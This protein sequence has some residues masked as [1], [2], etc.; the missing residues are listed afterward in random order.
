MEYLF[1]PGTDL[2][3]FRSPNKNDNSQNK[4]ASGNEPN[5]TCFFFSNCQKTWLLVSRRILAVSLCHAM[6][7]LKSPIDHN[8]MDRPLASKSRSLLSHGLTLPC[9]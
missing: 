4:S 8:A 2:F 3:S 1:S 9:S 5:Y 7:R 6:K